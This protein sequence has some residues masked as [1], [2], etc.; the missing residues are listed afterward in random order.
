MRFRNHGRGARIGLRRPDKGQGS[1][2]RRPQG[3]A[4]PPS[5][6]PRPAQ[7]GVSCSVAATSPGKD[8]AEQAFADDQ[9]GRHQHAHALGEFRIGRTLGPFVVN[10][11]KQ[12]AHRDQQGQRHRQVDAHADRQRRKRSPLGSAC[13]NSS[14]MTTTTPI[15]APMPISCQS[16]LPPST[17]LGNRRDQ[18]RLRRGERI[19][20]GPGRALETEGAVEQV[21]DRRNDD[22]AEDHA[23]HQRHLLPPWRRFD[24]LAGLQVLQVV[25]GD[26]GDAEDERRHE[27]GKCDERLGRLRID[28]GE[29]QARGS[30]RF[31]APT[32]CRRPKPGCSTR[33]SGRPCSR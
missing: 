20:V 9:A 32:E 30:P 1:P 16:R 8:H 4:A 14:M 28:A 21:E 22:C 25:V 2:Q 12:R 11:A 29:N 6:I 27:Q 10:P 18:R 26:R 15:A 31:Q 23:E 33:R 7:S 19:R 17:P 5:R 13:S 3:Q 24:Q